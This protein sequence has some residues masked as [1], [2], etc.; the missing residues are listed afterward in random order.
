MS[1]PVCLH[2]PTPACLPTPAR[3]LPY[4]PPSY[5]LAYTFPFTQL[6]H[7]TEL[8]TENSA[9][10]DLQG[11]YKEHILHFLGELKVPRIESISVHMFTPQLGQFFTQI[12]HIKSSHFGEIKSPQGWTV[13]SPTSQTFTPFFYYLLQAE[14]N[15]PLFFALRIL[16]PPFNLLFNKL[17][18]LH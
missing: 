6:R 18:E 16:H 13:R 15:L 12:L 8:F 9:F 14:N 11:S 7:N 4:L 2:L 10:V 3:S 5:Q 17:G 1:P